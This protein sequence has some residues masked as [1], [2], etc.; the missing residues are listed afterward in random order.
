MRRVIALAC[1]I[2]LLLAWTQ[3]P[4]LLARVRGSFRQSR[5]VL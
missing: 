1:A 2:G 4:L 5:P 3:G